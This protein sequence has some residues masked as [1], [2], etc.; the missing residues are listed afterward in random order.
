VWRTIWDSNA[1]AVEFERAIVARVIQRYLPARP[2]DPPDG[3]P[4]RWWESDQGAVCVSRAARHVTF[5]E[6]PEANTLANVMEL[7]P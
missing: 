3:L 5:V 1:E 4:G 7:L 2:L 6:A